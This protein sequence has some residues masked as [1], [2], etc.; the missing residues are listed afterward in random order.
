LAGALYI[1]SP[2][3]ARALDHF[4]IQVYEDDVNRPG[5]FALEVHS[6]YTFK[7]HREP[8]Y[9]GQVPAD[10]AFRLTLEPALG[11]TPWLELGGYFQTLYQPD[12]GLQYAGF[13]VRTK[14]VLPRSRQQHF[15]AG[16]NAEVGRVPHK[17][18]EQQWANE[19]RPIVGYENGY[20]LFDINP[21]FGYAL[22]GDEALKP[23]FE[24]AAK[25]AINTQQGFALGL[26]YYAGLGL[27]SSG[28]LPRS[29]QEHLLFA[30]FDLAQPAQAPE[31]EA[32]PW[33]LNIALGRSL[34]DA[35]DRE[36]IAKMIV[37]KPF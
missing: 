37:G 19:F 14:F 21:I 28:F 20:V 13:K 31:P 26:E 2:R 24:P 35:T 5:Q 22:T 8:D 4:E 18:E 30:V 1:I 10:R 16:I 29:E 15:F 11:V 33:E 6:N 23:H 17:V 3:P 9:P 7:G 32:D 34:T 25:A 27:L 12:A 36:W